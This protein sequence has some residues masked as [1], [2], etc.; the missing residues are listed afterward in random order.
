VSIVVLLIVAIFSTWYWDLL[1]L[2]EDKSKNQD[3]TQSN[4]TENENEQNQPEASA[5]P[6]GNYY[7]RALMELFLSNKAVGCAAGLTAA[8]AGCWLMDW[9]PYTSFINLFRPK[10][11]VKI[12][13]K[14]EIYTSKIRKQ[15]AHDIANDQKLLA[16]KKE[17]EKITP[18]ITETVLEKTG[19]TAALVAVG[20]TEKKEVDTKAQEEL[21]QKQEQL[22]KE[23]EQ[24]EETKKAIA[25]EVFQAGRELREAEDE[26]MDNEELET[27]YEKHCIDIS[28]T[29]DVDDE[30][31]FYDGFFKRGNGENIPAQYMKWE[32]NDVDKC[33]NEI[34][35]NRLTVEPDLKNNTD[36]ARLERGVCGGKGRWGDADAIKQRVKDLCAAN[37]WTA[38]EQPKKDADQ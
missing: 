14:Q 36:R 35:K 21:A 18:T 3:E 16:M 9:N 38:P 1:G 15:I 13:N 10:E 31:N 7:C 30:T 5:K 11:I 37:P 26:A 6:W 28:D 19:V 33:A 4:V 27:T 2:N 24:I 22:Q 20:V 12:E 32:K 8:V 17:L 23:I 34:L 25:E 29:H